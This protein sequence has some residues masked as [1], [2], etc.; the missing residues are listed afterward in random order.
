V[1]PPGLGVGTAYRGADCGCQTG[2]ANPAWAAGGARSAGSGDCATACEPTGAAT[3][4]ASINDTIRIRFMADPLLASCASS[5]ERPFGRL[6][7]DVNPA[8]AFCFSG[9]A[10]ILSILLK[11]AWGGGAVTK[12][13]IQRRSAAAL[14]PREK[15]PARIERTRAGFTSRTAGIE[16]ET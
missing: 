10:G 8:L 5:L 14:Y 12:A 4:P 13:A 16:R 15:T 9:F 3:L 1:L 2:D 11:P 7:V 6:T